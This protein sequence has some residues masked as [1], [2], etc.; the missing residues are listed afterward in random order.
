MDDKQLPVSMAGLPC[1]VCNEGTLE[2]WGYDMQEFK[3]DSRCPVC[4]YSSVYGP[5]PDFPR[6][7]DN[8][9]QDE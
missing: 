8:D 9:G 1:P 5:C 4:G 3:E 7:G 2:H 6:Q